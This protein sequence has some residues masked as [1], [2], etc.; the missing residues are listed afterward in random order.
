MPEPNV[1]LA[2]AGLGLHTGVYKNPQRAMSEMN[3]TAYVEKIPASV[4]KNPKAVKEWK[5]RFARYYELTKPGLSR[6]A[7]IEAFVESVGAGMKRGGSFVGELFTGSPATQRSAGEEQPQVSNNGKAKA[8]KEA[9]AAKKAQVASDAP[10]PARGAE[11]GAA[12]W[13]VCFLP[14]WQPVHTRT[15]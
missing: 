12:A 3:I 1:A 11:K 7:S 8:A 13:F 9:E 4:Q 6:T 10:A 5:D 15:A 14:C 2:A